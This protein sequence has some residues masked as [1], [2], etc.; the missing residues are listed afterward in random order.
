M[1]QAG[2]GGGDGAKGLGLMPQ[3][4]DVTELLD[5]RP[6]TGFQIRVVALCALVALFD[7]FDTQS[8]GFAAPQ[9]AAFLG[10]RMATLGQIFSIGL[11]GATAG[12]FLFG[13]L[14]D[15]LGRKWL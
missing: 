1:A 8:I 11:A 12:A 6:L 2:I 3:A 10:I 5:R 13:P 15:R 9:V 7:G 4:V 14:A